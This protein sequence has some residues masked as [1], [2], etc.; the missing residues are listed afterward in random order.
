MGLFMVYVYLR[1]LRKH[2]LNSWSPSCTNCVN[3]VV[4]TILILMQWT[5]VLYVQMENYLMLE[6]FSRSTMRMTPIQ[7]PLIALRSRA[8]L[9][10][11][12]DQVVDFMLIKLHF[13]YPR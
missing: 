11:P 12:N 4:A 7:Y 2:K 5:A 1:L 8:Q 3:F 10:P 9:C 13:S 6:T